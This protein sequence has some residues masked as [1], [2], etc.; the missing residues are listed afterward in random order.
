MQVYAFDQI[1]PVWEGI[2]AGTIA[3]SPTDW[4]AIQGRMAV[5]MAVRLLDGGTL[6]YKSAGPTPTWVNKDN[7]E[8]LNYADMMGEKGWK[9]QFTVNP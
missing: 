5:D 2:V 1:I 9:I 4:T 3:G 6:P 8:T 7:A